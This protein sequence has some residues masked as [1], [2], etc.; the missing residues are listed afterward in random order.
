MAGVDIS[1]ALLL[2]NGAHAIF[3]LR[4]GIVARIGSPHTAEA[5]HRE[6]QIS[7]WLNVSNIPTVEAVESLAQP[8]I[9]DDCPVTWWRLIPDHRPATPAELGAALGRLH[10][11]DPPSTF[12]LPEYQPFAGI[13][14]RINTTTTLGYEDKEWLVRHYAELRQRYDRLEPVDRRSVIH[15]DAWQGN[16]VVSPS[17][18]PVFLDLDKV[19]L[20]RPE[21]DL[22]QLAVDYADFTR[23]TGSGYR[24]FV[25]AYGGRDI[26]TDPQFRIF[27]DIQ[28]LRWTTFV[29]GL[30]HRDATARYEAEHRVACLRGR[31]AKPWTWNAL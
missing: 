7:R 9:I 15:G 24:S 31:V 29:L 17:G 18:I 10:L 8:L 13:D 5:A 28:E 30:S 2:R 19:S 25:D 23:L 20:G 12:D 1:G 11:L 14:T 27:A 22:V 4:D 26:S 21:W 6:L 3:E 16:L